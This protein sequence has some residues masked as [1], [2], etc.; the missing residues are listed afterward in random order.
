MFG[1]G[2]TGDTV[3]DAGAT[4]RRSRESI[5]IDLFMPIPDKQDYELPAGATHGTPEAFTLWGDIRNDPA[6]A[7][8]DARN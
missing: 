6:E 3:A 5:S 2:P 1:Q 4:I 7:D 8:V